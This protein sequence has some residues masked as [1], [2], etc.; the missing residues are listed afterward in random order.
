TGN[1]ARTQLENY[2]AKLNLQLIGSNS[3]TG[4]Y[5]HGD[6]TVQGRTEG[7]PSQFADPKTRGI[8]S[9]PSH[10]WKLEDSQVVGAS[11][12]ANL[13]WSDFS[14]SISVVPLGGP[15]PAEP[16]YRSAD[17]AYHNSFQ[18]GRGNGSEHQVQGTGSYFFETGAM[19]HEIRFGGHY[20]S[21][22]EKFTHFW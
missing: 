11:F 17:G 18:T 9:T 12:V 10:I 19:G 6:K 21:H 15:N 2:S 3:M 1:L 20:F 16:F 22:Q 4:F 8:Q 5:F 14:S 7:F 13:A